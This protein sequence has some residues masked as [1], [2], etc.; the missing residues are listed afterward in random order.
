ME[1]LVTGKPLNRILVK[2]FLKGK[3]TAKDLVIY[4]NAASEQGAQDIDALTGDIRNAHRMVLSTIGY[5][6]KAP[7]IEWVDV[8]CKGG[9]SRPLPIVC[10][11]ALVESMLQHDEKRFVDTIRGEDLD[12]PSFWYHM[13]AHP[14]FLRNKSHID[15]EK[16]I[17][18]KI[19]GDGAPTNKVEGLFTVSWSSL[20]GRGATV[21]TRQVFA[22]VPK[23]WIGSATLDVVFRRFAWSMNAL[24]DGVMP[25]TDFLGRRCIDA[26]R[27]LASGWKVVPTFLA[28]DWE[29][30]Q[31]VC[32]FPGPQN[33]P[34]MC[35]W[36]R[37]SPREGPLCWTTTSQTAKWRSTMKTHDSYLADCERTGTPVCDLFNCKTLCLEGCVSDVLHAMDEGL[38]PE[39]LGNTMVE[40]MQRGQWGATQKLK[41]QGLDAHLRAWY[42]EVKEKTTIA[43]K[44]TWERVRPPGEWP[45]FKAKAAATRHLVPYN[46]R[47]STE[48]NNGSLHDRWRLV[49]AQCLDQIYSLMS[50]CP[51]F[52][53]EAQRRQARTLSQQLMTCYSQLSLEAFANGL[54]MWKMKP[55]FH[56]SQHLLEYQFYINPREVWLYADED[57]QRIVK[58]IA[59]SCHPSTMH[60]MVILKWILTVFFDSLA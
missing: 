57:L 31:N 43:G 45:F 24:T 7:P 6:P 18:I 14:C 34:E 47:L 37:A 25:D 41:A 51:R 46:L 12:I 13:R 5:P 48:F 42:S 20:H 50:S 53:N 23:S 52:P 22:V 10:P 3:L 55:K 15:T 28:G 2:D 21:L 56:Q 59:V 30:Y 9:R 58:S 54:Q 16:S 26:G 29:F 38:L 4:A 8:P 32:H 49:V 35:P 17:A 27:E 33:V 44:I 40:V 39:I 11:I 60:Y 36:C 19:H 1:E